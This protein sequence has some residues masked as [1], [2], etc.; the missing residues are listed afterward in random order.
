MLALF[1]NPLFRLAGRLWW[2]PVLSGA[3]AWAFGVSLT[4][5][6]AA[7]AMLFGVGLTMV[8]LASLHGSGRALD[9]GLRHSVAGHRFLCP[10]CLHFGGR[11]FACGACRCE[12]E[13]FIVDT[14]GAYVN[15]CPHCHATLISRDGDDGQGIHAYCRNCS[16][17]SDLTLHERQVL[18]LGALSTGD[19]LSFCKSTL[20]EEWTPG[21]CFVV[22]DD[23]KRLTYLLN[24]EALPARTAPL[25]SPHAVHALEKVW[26]DGAEAAP[27]A[28]GRSLDR[29]SRLIGTGESR[30]ELTFCIGQHEMPPAAMHTLAARFDRAWYGVPPA[31]VSRSVAAIGPEAVVHHWSEGNIRVLGAL[32]TADLHSLERVTD[33]SG[34]PLLGERSAFQERHGPLTQL[35][36][37]EQWTGMPDPWPPRYMVQVLEAVWVDGR[38]LDP[39]EA[40]QAIDRFIRAVDLPDAWRKQVVVCVAEADLDPAVRM[41]LDSRFGE[42]RTSITADAFLRYGARAGISLAPERAAA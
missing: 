3:S 39:L 41:V 12:V 29:L 24:L 31:E 11:H 34:Q 20:K 18:V 26:L 14:D 5:P 30:R 21:E 4:A 9:E 8:V 2:L 38:G 1:R 22:A 15:D 25:P 13:R 35:V 40:G 42:V 23:G 17:V 19:F 7:A 33:A 32:R 36:D 28:L 27:L 10:E 16:A 37:L 6:L